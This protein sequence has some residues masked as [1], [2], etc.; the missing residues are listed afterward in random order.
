MLW[1]A[2][3]FQMQSEQIQKSHTPT[4]VDN[5]KCYTEAGT[6]CVFPD[7][8]EDAGGDGVLNAEVD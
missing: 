1:S 5:T 7:A 8:N 3:S 2:W 6:W 4:L